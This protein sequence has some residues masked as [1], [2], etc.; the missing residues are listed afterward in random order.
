METP[1]PIEVE[2]K[3]A[4]APTGPE[5][6]AKHSHLASQPALQQ[7][8]TNT[9]FDT[10]Q[11]DLAKA[12][13]ALRLRQVDGQVLQTVK[14]AGQGG[15]GLSQRQE[16]EWQ[17]AGPGLDLAALAELPPF[18]GELS[19]VLDALA[20]QLSTDFTRR[21]WQLKEG[22][23]G[24]VSHIELVVD[25]G[26]IISGDYRTP[27]REAELELKGG[28]PE[29]LWALALTLAEQVALR[30]SDSS[31][32]ARGNALSEQRWPLPQAHSP[33]EW[34]HRATLALDAYHDSQQASFLSDA[35][36]ALT[37]LADH[38]EL[39]AAERGYAQALPSALDAH[40]QP[41]TAYGKAA[42]A[43]AH[44]L[45]HQTALR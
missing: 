29:A 39:D 20:P 28:D 35:Q 26:E 23:Q 41:N 30:P 14:T 40:G 42:L 36:Q 11:G 27:I 4:L 5:A 7:L 18:Q 3:L 10:P 17:I 2:L 19:G 6:L 9:Y 16:W 38:P 13:I 22:A 8:L 25:E 33:A 45:A 31:K 44:R 15:G 12:R 34:L 21:S 1:T 43:L 24:Q 37:T 32:A